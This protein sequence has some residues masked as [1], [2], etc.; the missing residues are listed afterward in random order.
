[1]PIWDEEWTWS[2][3]LPK[4]I[5]PNDRMQGHPGSVCFPEGGH[6]L[7]RYDPGNYGYVLGAQRGRL[8]A[9]APAMARLLLELEWAGHDPYADDHACPSC[10]WPQGRTKEHHPECTWLAVMRV[11]GVRE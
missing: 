9:T 11:A 1:M 4:C 10:E 7:V 6:M 2:T 5:E 8:A 3:P